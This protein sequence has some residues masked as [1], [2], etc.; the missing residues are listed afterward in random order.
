MGNGKQADKGKQAALEFHRRIYDV[1]IQAERVGQ[2]IA[3]K[4]VS[5]ED[6]YNDLIKLHQALKGLPKWRD[7]QT[8]LRIL[9]FRRARL[10]VKSDKESAVFADPPF[11]DP[12]VPPL[13]RFASYHDA[14][15]HLAVNFADC[16]EDCIWEIEEDNRLGNLELFFPDRLKLERIGNES[17]DWLR[18]HD[19]RE[20]YLSHLLSEA[21]YLFAPSDLEEIYLRKYEPKPVNYKIPK[22]ER[23]VCPKCEKLMTTYRG[24]RIELELMKLYRN[25]KCFPCELTEVRDQDLILLDR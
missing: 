15:L 20:E 11:R 21:S 9:P 1:F 2:R 3:D 16:M 17:L 22:P 13:Y 23:P 6:A 14:A 25:Y 12:E 10:A 19:V 8:D 7:A 24:P 4:D 5:L 18:L